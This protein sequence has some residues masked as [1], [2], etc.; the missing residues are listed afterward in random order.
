MLV[1]DDATAALTDGLPEPVLRLADLRT[2]TAPAQLPTVAGGDLAFLQFSSGSTGAPRGVELTHDNVLANLDQARSASAARPDDVLV[3]WM[4][5]FH[6]MGLIGTHLTPLAIGLKQVR[7]PPLAFAKRPALWFTTAHRHRATLL[8]AANFALALAVRRVPAET[9]AGLDLSAVRC[10][11]V[12]AEPISPAVWRSFLA[13]T[14]PAG[15][16]PAA[17]RPVYG[18]AEATLAVTFPPPGEVAVPHVLDRAELSQ[19]RAVPTRP[20]PHAVELMDLGHPVADCAVRVVDDHGRPLA[21]QRIGQIEVRGPNVARG[22]H[23]D[24]QASRDTFV[25]G[26]LRTGDLGFLRDGRLCVTGRA[27][28]VVFVNGR[29]FHA[30]DLETVAVATPACPA[31]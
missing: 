16:D 2:G 3:S 22:Y 15:L 30:A 24:P 14:R 20:G 25:D 1:T 27:K 26:W 6:D 29:T 8:S 5:Y 23:R 4:P 31:R 18:L 12:G 7:I 10:V 19:G 9:L 17:L 21:D 11:V 28:D 13:H